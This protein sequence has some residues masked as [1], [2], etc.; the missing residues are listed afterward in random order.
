M[1]RTVLRKETMAKAHFNHI[2]ARIRDIH[3]ILVTLALFSWLKQSSPSLW[4]KISPRS[5]V[6]DRN[7][8]LP[9][10]GTT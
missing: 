7:Q 8:A 9:P 2:I 4:M 6:E 5:G 1:T 3:K 10:D